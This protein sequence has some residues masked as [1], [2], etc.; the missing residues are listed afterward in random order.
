MQ[1]KEVKQKQNPLIRAGFE[2]M[3]SRAVTYFH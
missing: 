2:E 1:D 3:E